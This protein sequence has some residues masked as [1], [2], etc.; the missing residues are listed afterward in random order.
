MWQKEERGRVDKKGIL[1]FLSAG[2]R[3]DVCFWSPLEWV[4]LKW[5]DMS[6]V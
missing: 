2:T 1:Q 4:L 6:Y 3:G 5:I